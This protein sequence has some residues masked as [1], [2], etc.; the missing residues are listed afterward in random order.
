MFRPVVCGACP[1]RS[2]CT[3]AKHGARHLKLQPRAEHAHD[4][5]AAFPDHL[6]V[7]AEGHQLTLDLTGER[8]GQLQR[9]PFPATE[10]PSSAERSRSHVHDS[11]LVGLPCDVG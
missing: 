3:R 2:L 7:P 9:V 10:Q 6:L 8:P 11:H 1:A 4:Q 5:P